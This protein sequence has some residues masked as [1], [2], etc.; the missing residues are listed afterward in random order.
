MKLEFPTYLPHT[1]VGNKRPLFIYPSNQSRRSRGNILQ[2]QVVAKIAAIYK[3]TAAQVVLRH[4]TQLG[5]IVI[6]KS[7]TA[8]RIVSNGQIF[9]FTISDQDMERMTELDRGRRFFEFK[10]FI[11]GFVC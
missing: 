1:P 4:L 6:P 11:P 3:K 8:E 7:V 10:N 5:A 2:E 9:D